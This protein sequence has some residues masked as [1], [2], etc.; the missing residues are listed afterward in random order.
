[1]PPPKPPGSGS[2]GL[3]YYPWWAWLG[4]LPTIKDPGGQAP[5]GRVQAQVGQV[6][7]SSH[8]GPRK[9]SRCGETVM[10]PVPVYKRAQGQ[11]AR[12]CPAQGKRQG[13]RQTPA[14][15]P[16]SLAQG[17]EGFEHGI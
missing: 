6:E 13:Q 4:C 17:T 15:I 2:S 12:S 1:M 10:P 11:G 9:R 7:K 3:S 5:G 8:E 16:S 14:L